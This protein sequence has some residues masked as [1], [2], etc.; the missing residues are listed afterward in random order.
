MV[1]EITWVIYQA[2]MGSN[3]IS[4]ANSNI[5]FHRIDIKGGHVVNINIIISLMV[6]VICGTTNRT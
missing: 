4:F 5:E 2:N 6:F 1:E 3:R